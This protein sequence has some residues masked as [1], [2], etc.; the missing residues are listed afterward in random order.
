MKLLI[1]V[2]VLLLLYGKGHQQ[3]SGY[4]FAK[5]RAMIARKFHVKNSYGFAFIVL[6]PSL[7]LMILLLVLR[8]NYITYWITL[9]IAAF[10]LLACI[11]EV[12]RYP[13]SLMLPA[14][15]AVKIAVLPETVWQ[16]NRHY[17]TPFFWFG[18]LGAPG[19]L[20][21]A[22]TVSFEQSTNP[23]WQAWAKKAASMFE[24]LPARLLGFA[25]AIVGNFSATMT[26]WLDLLPAPSESNH[27]FLIQT[28]SRAANL[29][30]DIDAYKAQAI[31]QKLMRDAL[32]VLAG[33]F[34][35]L[36]MVVWF[37]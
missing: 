35:V 1:F 34:A 23:L 29:T 24:W 8:Q 18:L 25:Y 14:M 26:I 31:A 20:A 12:A 21:Y 6:L 33:I 16:I 11:A 30:A 3:L 7:L 27:Y 4:G 22:M 2:F 17:V 9:F 37:L 10:V 13:E 32:I 19:A 28:L 36:V 5:Y 15:N